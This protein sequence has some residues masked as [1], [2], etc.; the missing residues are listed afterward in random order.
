[1]A[2]SVQCQFADPNSTWTSLKCKKQSNNPVYRYP[3]GFLRGGFSEVTIDPAF[4]VCA[5]R[6][7]PLTNPPRTNFHIIDVI[8]ED[9]P[10]IFRK[11]NTNILRNF[12]AVVN[13]VIL[14]FF[15]ILLTT[16]LQPLMGVH[17]SYDRKR[18]GR[19]TRSRKNDFKTENCYKWSPVNLSSRAYDFLRFQR[20]K[21]I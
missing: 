20:S 2:Q 7:N 11:I 1:M 6:E 17:R 12:I 21:S 19:L 16:A 3:L 15:S 8:V 18:P 4:N 5:L 10:R 9:D 13:S 14:S